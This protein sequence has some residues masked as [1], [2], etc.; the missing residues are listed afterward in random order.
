MNRRLSSIIASLLTI[1]LLSTIVISGNG[2][3]AR[4]LEQG[5][6][7]IS[8]YDETQRNS[9]NMLNYL[10]VLTQ[11]INSAR[12]S[13]LFVEE[14]YS[15]LINNT[16]PN[17]I[18]ENT[19]F[20]LASILD[21]LENYRM[22]AVQRDRLKYIYEQNQAQALRRSLP[23]PL[24]LISLSKSKKIMKDLLSLTFMAVDAYA[25]YIDQKA[26]NDLRD[27]EA[28]WA[29][30]DEEAKGLHGIRKQTFNYMIETVNAYK[31]SGD[32][33]LN[34]NAVDEFV[35]WK[36]NTNI[37]QR[38]LFLESNH[39]TYKDFGSYWLTLAQSYYANEDFD[40]CLDALSNYDKL[41]TRI[42]RKDY[43]LAKVLPM[44]IVAAKELK[45]EAEYVELAG[46][47]AERIIANS[48]NSDWSLR[49]F[50]G[51]TFV[52]LYGLTK[53]STYIERAYKIIRDNVNDLVNEQKSLN[54]QY[55]EEFAAKPF[56]KGATKS[57][58]AAIDNY[59]KQA[60]EERDKALAPVYEPFLL[61]CELLFA[62][63]GEIGIDDAEKAKIDNILHENGED[64]FLIPALDN[65]FR[66][67]GKK[68][69][70]EK[71]AAEIIFAGSELKVPAR[72][73]IKS[74]TMTVTIRE[75]ES[76]EPVTITDWEIVKVDRVNRHDINSF[77]AT[78]KSPTAEK[79]RFEAGSTIDIT[80]VPNPYP[81]AVHLSAKYQAVANKSNW[82]EVV[83]VWEGDVKFERRMD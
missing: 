31:L 30:D 54:R 45:N 82:W 55:M 12:N 3:V 66:F 65:L 70:E 56:P 71:E 26:A 73:M 15:S 53:D 22:I 25:S 46:Q 27:M 9:M 67:T 78:Y 1:V 83:K 29:L 42:F 39:R 33:A 17:A 4:A 20:H 62:L 11:Q 44:A 77:V 37:V 5:N 47:F 60:K 10:A 61:N 43:D 74:A 38:I 69:S 7:T 51:Q 16:H 18:D 81:D 8:Q 48:D 19:Q 63:A 36:N 6:D 23:S 21:A 32:Q 13:R 64:I 50:A 40:K 80:I 68:E 75:L 58:K 49:Y 28:T 72:S 59:N 79:H 76:T 34:E 14:A 52:E 57:V 41:Q 24:P 35:A 2:A